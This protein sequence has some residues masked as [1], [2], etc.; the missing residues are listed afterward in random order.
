MTALNVGVAST[1]SVTTPTALMPSFM[2]AGW[3]IAIQWFAWWSNRCLS[4][5]DYVTRPMLCRHISNSW[6]NQWYSNANACF[7]RS[8]EIVKR[9]L[10]TE[11]HCIIETCWKMEQSGNW[12]SRGFSYI[13][14]LF[15][16]V[17]GNPYVTM[18]RAASRHDFNQRSTRFLLSPPDAVRALFRIMGCHWWRVSGSQDE[19]GQVAARKNASNIADVRLI[20]R[21]W[22]TNHFVAQ[23]AILNT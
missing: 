15:V 10:K 4:Q 6:I 18:T 7:P 17:T 16:T 14:K 11:R 1:V 8:L 19:Y 3:Q 12:K 23:R 5:A 13:R 21:G 9:W 20:L 2:A 22:N